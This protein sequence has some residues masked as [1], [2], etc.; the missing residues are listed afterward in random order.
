MSAISLRNLHPLPRRLGWL[1]IAPLLLLLLACPS[2]NTPENGKPGPPGQRGNGRPNPEGKGK[3]RR[4]EGGRPPL[5]SMAV[6]TTP[7]LRGDI[8][9]YYSAS[10]SLDPDK[11]AAV[12]SRV[13]G[14]IQKVLAEEGDRVQE[15]QPLLLIDDTEYRHR[16]VQAEVELEMLRLRW[17]RTEEMASTGL[18]SVEA[19]DESASQF[20]AAEATWAL[21]SLDLSYTK[22]A[23]PFTGRVVM[24]SVDQ[25]QNV[26]NGTPLFTLADMGRLLARV[27]VPAREFRSIQTD[28]AVQLMVDSTGDR[29]TGSIDLISP[30]VDSQSGT[31]KVTVAIDDYPPTTRPGDFAQV[32]IITDRHLETLLVPRIAVLTEHEERVVYLA[33][34]ETAARRVVKVGFE[35]DDS[36]EI[37]EGLDEGDS[38]IVQGQRSLADGQPISILEPRSS[39]DATLK[40]PDDQ[41]S[42]PEGQERKKPSRGKRRRRG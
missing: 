32:S 10:A 31:I 21:A 2:E 22:V 35:D 14:V 1:V 12:L 28:Q 25:G 37:L 41:N 19:L 18:V 39:D 4:P 26:S 8:D 5:P 27:H 3:G 38:V 30:V 15:G 20:K 23:S 40:A 42:P 9:T 36:A 24:R 29:L 16:L 6:A 34:G 13:N 33:D 7:A 17:N 11:Q